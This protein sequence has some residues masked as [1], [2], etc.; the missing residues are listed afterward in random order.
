MAYILACLMGYLLGCSNMAAY[1]AKWKKVDLKNRGS[2]NNGASNAA[3]V[4]GWR[5]GILTALHD[6]G[7]A[8][9][10]VALAR[11]LFLQQPYIGEV[12]GVACVLGHVFPVFLKFRGGKG[13]ASYLGMTLVLNWKLALILMLT[14]AVITLMADYIVF[15]TFTTV[16]AVP[17]YQGVVSHSLAVALILAVASA[18]VIW[19]H[20]ENIVKI[21]NGTEIGLRGT[22]SK[23]H[24][25]EKEKA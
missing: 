12:A 10:A 16:C 2:G 1:L 19:K 11:W 13:F 20:R 5:A 14:V 24:R 18:V 6:I 15:G 21:L 7:K 25:I 22:L 23:K 17:V 3:I 9:L 8:A 4:L